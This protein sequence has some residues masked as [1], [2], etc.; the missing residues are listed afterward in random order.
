MPEEVQL[1][2][3]LPAF[4]SFYT[5]LNQIYVLIDGYQDGSKRK[6]AITKIYSFN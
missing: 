6:H 2:E 3:M 4:T 5:A 1:R